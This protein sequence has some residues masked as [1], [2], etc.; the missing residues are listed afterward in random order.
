MPTAIGFEHRARH[1]ERLDRALAPRT[2]FFAAAGWTNRVFAT[3]C[4]A[5]PAMVSANTR[6]FLDALGGH[7]ARINGPLAREVATVS[8]RGFALDSYL[9]RAEQRGAQDYCRNCQS[10]DATEWRRLNRELDALVNG[11]H[12]AALLAPIFGHTRAYRDVLAMVRRHMSSALEFADVGHRIA[13]GDSLIR[14]VRAESFRVGL[15]TTMLV[16]GA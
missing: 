15:R 1:Y 3:L 13:I 12:P 9:V 14:H 6:R 2:R 8:S 11:V 16:P 10:D 4:E 7:L 5:R